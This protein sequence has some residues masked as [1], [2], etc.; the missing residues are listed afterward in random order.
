MV[1]RAGPVEGRLLERVAPR[2]VAQA[3]KTRMPGVAPTDRLDPAVEHR[4]PGSTPL[5]GAAVPSPSEVKSKRLEGGHEHYDY[6]VVGSGAGGGI[7]ASRLAQAGHRVLMVEAGGP[8]QPV[9]SKVPAFHAIASENPVLSLEYGAKHYSDETQ[10]KKD[11]KYD[12]GLGGVFYPRGE[13][14]GGSTLVNAMFTV[15][16][17]AGDFDRIAEATGDES[18]RDSAMQQYRLRIENAEYR[19]ILKALDRIGQKLG[20]DFLKNRG[21]HGFNGWLTITQ[22]SVKLLLKDGQ[23]QRV[24][25][26]AVAES[27]AADARVKGQVR[28]T[29]DEIS[30]ALQRLDPND[31]RL[32][33]Q[34]AEGVTIAPLA[35]SKDGR[36]TGVRDLIM[37]T[38]RAAPDKLKIKTNAL[39]E[40]II[41]DENNTA[42]GVE[43]REGA[44]LQAVSP[45]SDGASGTK[46]TIHARKGV[47]IAA[48]TFG[49]PQLLMLSG[50][51][52]KEELATHGIASRVDLPGVGKNLHDRYEV[53]VISEFGKDFPL[54]AGTTFKAD[55]NDPNFK[56]WAERDG[57]LYATNGQV[58]SIIRKSDPSLAKPDL[59][60]FGL[61][62]AFPEYYRG[63]SA[64][65]EAQHNVFTWVI[66]K[67][68]TDNRAGTV[69]LRSADPRMQ[70]EINF[71]SFDEG[72]DK[73]GVH[74]DK[75][76]RGIMAGVEFAR[77][78]NRRLADVIAKEQLPGVDVQTQQQIGDWVKR[79]AWGHH[80]TGTSAIGSVVDSKLRVFGTKNLWVADAS[81][82]PDIPG[83][84][85]AMPTMMVAEKAS[86]MILA[87]DKQ[88][89]TAAAA[90]A[91]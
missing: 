81:V 56:K 17:H 2:E 87:E 41:F 19:P 73:N 55:P 26:A 54:L 64:N 5:S 91:R 27:H 80:A 33:S 63:Y 3:S 21:G 67:A 39:V 75:D 77:A 79:T 23:L 70:P 29:F 9:Q 88:K 6:V 20:L 71:H 42:T 50:V 62:G 31:L 43:L 28:T 25:A 85:I 65:T 12:P 76:L 47:V 49:S 16:P 30:R 84:F 37:A 46:K 89:Q 40:R 45:E 11:P 61:P 66:L 86:D 32:V 44:H 8:K 18:W 57:G 60:I 24:V 82:F 69:T 38:R 22:P 1:Q 13:G 7:V 14:V 59:F 53:P 36:R 48:G 4:L 90:A 10:Q 72:H 83:F 74:T 78:M 68:R 58:I 15:V 34:N 51:G 35:I 52:P